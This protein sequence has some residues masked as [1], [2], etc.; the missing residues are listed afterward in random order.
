MLDWDSCLL[1]LRSTH[2]IA[3]QLI[4]S[5]PSVPLLSGAGGVEWR[6]WILT[7]G[8]ML[9]GCRSGSEETPSAAFGASN[10]SGMRG[11]VS[12]ACAFV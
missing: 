6:W 11:A 5:Q 12:Y 7:C 3:T 1:C 4:V 8:G 10:S 2:L 9:G